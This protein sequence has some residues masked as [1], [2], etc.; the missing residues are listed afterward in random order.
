MEVA[1][2][3]AFAA[4]VHTVSAETDIV[5]ALAEDAVFFTGAARFVLIALGAGKAGGHGLT[6]RGRKRKQK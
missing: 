5:L 3:A 6:L 4:V 2:F 1:G